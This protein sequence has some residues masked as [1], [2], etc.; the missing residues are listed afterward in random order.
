MCRGDGTVMQIERGWYVSSSLLRRRLLRWRRQ[1]RRLH[2][3]R[4]V[5]VVLILLSVVL[6]FHF[7]R[8]DRVIHRGKR[9]SRRLLRRL[10]HRILLLL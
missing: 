4:L 5:L 6:N 9:D 1:L 7:F 10:F 3:R 8:L 2:L